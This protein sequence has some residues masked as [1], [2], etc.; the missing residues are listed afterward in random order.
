VSRKIIKQF[1]FK[2]VT[3]ILTLHV[4]NQMETPDD[5]VLYERALELSVKFENGAWLFERCRL[6]LNLDDTPAP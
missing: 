5:K 4:M 1:T 2:Q 3:D 6:E